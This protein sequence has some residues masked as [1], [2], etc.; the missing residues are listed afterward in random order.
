[1]LISRVVRQHAGH[2]SAEQ[3]AYPAVR[4]TPQNGNIHLFWQVLKIRNH[5]RNTLAF[6]KRST[7]FGLLTIL[8]GHRY[9][10]NK[11]RITN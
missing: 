10:N 9:S 2:G 8:D 5:S 6:V 11:F 1:M 4:F 3:H 7:Y